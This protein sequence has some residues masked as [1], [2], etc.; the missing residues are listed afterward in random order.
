MVLPF[1]CAE[2][3]LVMSVDRRRFACARRIAR[4]D[5]F[6]IDRFDRYRN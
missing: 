3:S 1:A 4:P 6:I 2:E 5:L